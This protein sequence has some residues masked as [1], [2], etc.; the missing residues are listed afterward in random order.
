MVDDGGKIVFSAW[1]SL[2]DLHPFLAM[3][4]ELKRRGHAP[5]IV[6][7][8]AYRE[9]VERLGV[10]WRRLRPD[11]SDTVAR[12]DMV[13]RALDPRD[14]PRYIFQE[15]L[16]PSV[17]E[18]YEDVAAAL[19]EDGGAD[20]YVSHAVPPIGAT[21][22]EKTGVPWVSCTL[23]PIAFLSAFDPPEFPQTPGVRPLFAL[24]PKIAEI[25]YEIGKATTL[26]WVESVRM[27][28]Q[29]LGL[30]A[31]GN[32]IF[33]GQHSP[34]RTLALFSPLFGTPQPDFPPQTIVT[35]FPFF[36]DSDEPSPAPA[37]EVLAFLDA[38]EP[39][40]V[41]TLGSSAVWIGGDAFRAAIEAGRKLKRRILLLTGDETLA[42]TPPLPE[43]SAAFPYAPHGCVM[44]RACVVIHHGGVGTTGQALRAGRP[45]A[46]IPFGQDQPDNARRCVALGVARTVGRGGRGLERLTDAVR[47]LLENPNYAR[48]AQEVG[49]A[50][51]AERGT[52]R[53][54]DAVE[55]VLRRAS[56]RRNGRDAHEC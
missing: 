33:E 42:E 3:A 56:S 31:S 22:A 7:L 10:A 12:A 48:R 43:G 18:S 40:I 19:A 52:A 17:R 38:G 5:C 23:S 14:G 34:T 1:G 32:P 16:A 8:S 37:R 45:M 29:D 20:L 30:P 44:P 9:I 15:I 4:V 51:R 2:G 25:L 26:P 27:L 24:H 46:I 36:E 55:E 39:P 11:S 28:R 47:E 6:T 41:V 49:A 54:C 21:A 53:A 13:R 50:I 35:G